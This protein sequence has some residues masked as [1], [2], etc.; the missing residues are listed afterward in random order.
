MGKCDVMNC[1]G[2]WSYWSIW[3]EDWEKMLEKR[4]RALIKLDGM[5]F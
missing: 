2:E 5:Q 1:A 4:I 3:Y